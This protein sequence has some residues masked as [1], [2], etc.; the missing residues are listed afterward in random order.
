MQK[1]APAEILVVEDNPGDIRLLEEA[2][3]E[4]KV[5]CR[6][7]IT[8]DGEQALEFLAQR[9]P[10]AQSPRPNLV[11]LDLNLPRK[12]GAEVLLAIK[13]D[14]SLRSIPVLVLSTS[15]RAEDI[16]QAYDLHAN[17]YVPKPVDLERLVEVGRL[18][19]AFWL[20]TV[21]LPGCG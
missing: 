6:L 15:T 7:H 11:L 8:R 19:E 1:Q 2:L 20:S 12:N 10:Y 4:A 13:Q 14:G 21:L 18:I 17:C 16:A 3:K 9:G 5:S